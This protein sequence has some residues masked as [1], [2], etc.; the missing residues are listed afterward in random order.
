[1]ELRPSWKAASCAA[2]QEL[3]NI[4][5]NPKV[6]YRVHKSPPLVCVLRKIN[7][8]QTTS[9]Y[10]SKIRFNI[11]RH[12]RLGLPSGLFLVAFPPISYVHSPSPPFVL[13][14]PPIS[15]SLIWRRV[16]VVKLLIMQFSLTSCHFVRLWSKYPQHPVLKHPQS[17][18]LT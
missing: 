17:V 12:L 13:H 2:T 4:L 11:V 1:M 7:L 3:P 8:V 16:E 5:W 18:F 10:L 6:H 14:A 15:S 9:S